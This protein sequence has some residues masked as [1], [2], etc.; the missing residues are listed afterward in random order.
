[1]R[2][3]LEKFRT[4]EQ[5]LSK[6]KG[7]FVLFA[8]IE[9]EEVQNKW[10]VVVSATWLEEGKKKDLDFVIKQ[11]Q[12]KFSNDEM[13]FLAKV[14]LLDPSEPFVKNITSVVSV[15]GGSLEIKDSAFNNTFVKHAYV[16]TSQK[17][18]TVSLA[19]K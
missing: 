19:Q 7:D 8:L 2:Q 9:L 13:M 5:D 6:Q 12:S 4:I 3:L 10:D 16:I 17:D 15:K 1:M 11:I 14:V 18:S